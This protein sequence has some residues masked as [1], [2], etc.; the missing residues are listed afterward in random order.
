MKFLNFS[1]DEHTGEKPSGTSPAFHVEPLEPRLLLSADMSLSA[2]VG[3]ALDVTL[4]LDE[5]RQEIQ[6]VDNTMQTVLQSQ[7]LA[8]T[9]SVNIIGTD[10]DDTLTIDLSIPFTLPEGIS[11]EDS[12]DSDNDTFQVIGQ[13]NVFNVTG[14]NQGNING[15]IDFAGIENLAGDVGTDMFKFTATGR[16]TGMIDGASG[17][18]DSIQIQQ[19]GDDVVLNYTGADSGSI[20]RDGQVVALYNRIQ[21]LTLESSGPSPPK[22]VT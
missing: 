14:E 3:Q 8:E 19:N 6:I 11:F 7:A 21:A 16:I 22:D 12:S 4:R 18:Q 2:V 5:N 15:D 1:K 13:D 20:E 9:R 17:V 10:Q